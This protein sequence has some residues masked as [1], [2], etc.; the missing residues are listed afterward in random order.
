MAEKFI[1]E[2]NEQG[3]DRIIA[4]VEAF[5]Q[6][7]RQVGQEGTLGPGFERFFAQFDK[8]AAT[9][10]R[11]IAELRSQ[12]E[13]L[14]QMPARFQQ[15]IPLG[16]VGRREAATL[17]V[18][19][20]P[21]SSLRQEIEQRVTELK[22]QQ[23]NLE[24]LLVNEEQ[25]FLEAKQREA[26]L[27]E[28]TNRLEATRA[29]QLRQ[30][31]ALK[32]GG[33]RLQELVTQRENALLER[34]RELRQQLNEQMARIQSVVPQ[35]A[36]AILTKEVQLSAQIAAARQ[37]QA[38]AEREVLA[39]RQAASGAG[40]AKADRASGTAT[41][42]EKSALLERQE[43]VRA[44][45]RT[46]IES[47]QRA[48]ISVIR[49]EQERTSNM[50][51]L[52]AIESS[53]GGS[54]GVTEILSRLRQVNDALADLLVN[55]EAALRDILGPEFQAQLAETER[56]L[57][58]FEGQEILSPDEEAKLAAATV[59][60]RELMDQFERIP[61]KGI[62]IK[63]NEDELIEGMSLLNR[64]LL[65][66]ARDFGRRFTATLQF[67][68]SGALL[69]GAQRL[70]R[71][72]FDA[73]VDVERTFA[74]ISTSL[75]FDID[76][77]RGT[78]AFERQLEKVRRQTLQIADDFNALPTEVN[79][80]AFQMV[81]RFSNVEA[82]MIATRAQIL[83][84]RVATIDQA[85]ALRA[86]TAVAE[87]YSV[88][89]LGIENDQ[90]RQIAQAK[91]YAEALD[92]AT[93]IQQ[94][95]GGTVE[96][97]LEGS[98]GLAELFRTLGFALDET[99]AIVAT[100]IRKTGQTGQ[101]VTD[102]LGRAFSQFT[103]KE[104]RDELL[105][106]AN[107]TDQLLLTPT[108][109]LDSGATALFKIIDQ[110]QE[111]DAGLQNRIAQIIGQRRETP[112]V[113]AFLQGASEGSIE[114]VLG[115]L[116]GAGGA[117]ENRLA[118]LLATVR[119][120]IEGISTEF[121]ELAQN[122][123]RLGVIT[124]IRVLLTILESVLKLMNGLATAALDVVEALNRVRIPFLNAGLG[125][126]LKTLLAMV[127]AALSLRTLI[128]GIKLVANARGANTLIDIF[129]GVL[130]G[131]TSTPAGG[132]ANRAG[133]AL[134]IGVFLTQMRSADGLLSKVGTGIRT[135]FISPLSTALT[136]LETAK[137]R[138]GLF[139]TA[140][141]TNIVTTGRAV[142]AEGA[143]AIARA[144]TAIVTGLASLKGLGIGGVLAKLGT[145]LGALASRLGSLVGY[146]LAA[147]G[148]F[149]AIQ[150]VIG[151]ITSFARGLAD[152][153]AATAKGISARQQELQAEAQAAGETLTITQARLQAVTE[154]V[155]ELN[156]QLPRFEDDFTSFI[157]TAL[158][159]IPGST[160][161]MF[162]GS[163]FG[164]RKER[165]RAS[166]ELAFAEV[167]QLQADLKA[168][169][170][171][172]GGTRD[173]LV[174]ELKPAQ[175]KIGEILNALVAIEVDDP[176]HGD[177]LGALD[178]LQASIDGQRANIPIIQQ[179][180]GDVATL[181][182]AMGEVLTPDQIRDALSQLG[183]DLQLGR[184]TMA[185]ARTALQQQRAEALN[186]LA[187]AEQ[188]GDPEMAAEYK[189]ALDDIAVQDL[190]LLEQDMQARIAL[191][192]GIVSNSA[193][194]AAELAIRRDFAAQAAADPNLG[195]GIEAAMMQ[196]IRDLEREYINALHE[197]AIARAQFAVDQAR[198]FEQR[199]AALAQLQRAIQAQISS[200]I[201]PS[202]RRFFSG[203]ITGT[204]E[205]E[206]QY[207]GVIER[208]ADERMRH[209]ILVARNSTLQNTS[210]LDELAAIAATVNALRAEISFMRKRGD[211]RQ[212][213]LAKEIELRE[214]VANLRLAESDRRA[215]FFRLTAGTGDEIRAAQA[216]L[217]AANDRLATIVSLGGADTQQGYEAEL[218]V[219]QAQK[220]LADLAL[221]QA[222]LRRRVASDLTD[223]FA[224]SLLD[225]HAAQEALRHAGG[226]LEKL[227]AQ[228]S[229]AE[230]ES[231]A[232]REFYNRRLSDLDFLF[233][234][235]QIG[236]GQYIGALRALQGGIDRTT[237]QG[238]ELWREIELQIRG[239]VD[240]ANEAFNI[241][242][243][244]RLPTLFEVRRA[245]AADALG[246]NYQ[247]L[248]QQEINVFVSDNVDVD[249]VFAALESSF[250]GS[251]DLEAARLAQGGA[252][253]TIG[254]FG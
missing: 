11:R 67:A 122:L 167:Q 171:R 136:L 160:A 184:T 115:I 116:E 209:A 135:L 91:L 77:E 50:E 158:H 217:R 145:G 47:E 93:A 15:D 206:N 170:L 189:R 181:I 83:A 141:L 42:E 253:I 191:V 152:D 68:L 192:Q 113:S 216:E 36:N 63:L 151:T 60:A 40:L 179:L 44:R 198:T 180:F 159:F 224:Q 149:F 231:R 16:N 243:E 112:F 201:D 97:I 190:Q 234:T 130:G 232:Q 108:D 56:E 148:A 107:T 117:A 105:A 200:A 165:S 169:N 177:S 98:A 103:S 194:I 214:A 139:T 125:D 155:K 6:T 9:A 229:L 208:I 69:F 37:R 55:S 27:A 3:L 48:V 74:D 51:R 129:K 240:S 95:F 245:L 76:A 252:G 26:N 75:E 153:P 13:K 215:A 35:E 90:D 21:G 204:L 251:I 207:A 178:A 53:G 101:T 45:L 43:S 133:G 92:D 134:G 30:I 84:T 132:L 195:G 173:I 220:R 225:V 54:R 176:K 1:F 164:V 52:A 81:S 110:Y 17:G 168:A 58:S 157:L 230:A 64:L 250:G 114:E 163:E 143:L 140:L 193:R 254:G 46:A 175:E 8:G 25:R 4:K 65:G 185:Q 82:A 18:E 96:D 102:R 127:T 156:E 146:A 32:P 126:A 166:L 86:L 221:R 100:T 197:E 62:P 5:R 199:I 183:L 72:F 154:R 34:Q 249:A 202:D 7:L 144:R 29:N 85:E 244:I 174:D 88:T 172:L 111:L 142:I 119:G 228:K 14:S 147:G 246:V 162:P 247:D 182:T 33:S 109:F 99:F 49:L 241:P 123:E 19:V 73:A 196:E 187:Q 138:I 218:A 203:R 211:D 87:S 213:I 226:D 235:D 150:G 238:E 59:R 71:E 39:A 28:F 2:F 70:L 78:A 219:L 94:R 106:V 236:R 79:E 237:R 61:E 41:E 57:R 31:A 121:Q 66:A 128:S 118:I 239:I 131:S 227:E 205:Q 124:P 89:L 120:T 186:G 12:I 233:R 222:D 223:S 137:I 242:T 210:A 188:G 104:V 80:A 24:R 22:A 10:T 38:A 248:R 212:E 23:L 161:E 20:Q